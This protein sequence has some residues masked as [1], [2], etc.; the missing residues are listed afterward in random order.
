MMRFSYRISWFEEL[1]DFRERYSAWFYNER[2]I[3][4]LPGVYG[5]QYPAE[6]FPFIPIGTGYRDMIWQPHRLRIPPMTLIDHVANGMC[7]RGCPLDLRG[8]R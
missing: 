2:P 4:V 1:N 5:M 7:Y 3:G 6:P 8:L